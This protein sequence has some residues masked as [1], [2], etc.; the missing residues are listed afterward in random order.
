MST[1][2]LQFQPDNPDIHP[3]ASKNFVHGVAWTKQASFQKFFD[4]GYPLEDIPGSFNDPNQYVLLLYL[5]QSSRPTDYKAQHDLFRTIP[6]AQLA[7]ENCQELQVVIVK[8]KNT[9]YEK[10]MG[11]HQKCVAIMPHWGPAAHVHRFSRPHPETNANATMAPV[12]KKRIR[13][14]SDLPQLEY[15]NHMH[16]KINKE[17]YHFNKVFNPKLVK[18]AWG[19]FAN[20]VQHY[21]SAL[22]ELTPVLQ[23][24]ASGSAAQS[25]FGPGSKDSK[26]V[27]VVMVTNVARIQFLINYVCAAKAIQMDLSNL[28][29]FCLDTA[30][31]Q[32][33]RALELQAYY[34]PN[35][36][37]IPS[38]GKAETGEFGDLRFARIMIAKVYS[39]HLV[40]TL[41][42]DVLFMDT[43]VIPLQPEIVDYFA[44]RWLSAS[45]D[46]KKDI[47]LQYDKNER[48]EQAPFSAN[49]GFYF[50]KHNWKTQYFFETFVRMEEMILRVQS[51]Q[52][53]MIHLL[54]EF[55][56]LVGLKVK[57]MGGYGEDAN[58]FP[59]E[60]KYHAHYTFKGYQ[61][62]QIC[63]VDPS[64]IRD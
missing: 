34:N 41:G 64:C 15:V 47:Y 63:F 29:V 6:N 8:Q 60:Y 14:L 26:G 25:S 39:V 43:D 57:V 40:N 2:S 1:S 61:T 48:F 19:R 46:Q 51:H 27:I 31:Y 28:I 59:S 37:P 38:S 11:R 53:V 55:Q 16:R 52:Q 13:R 24:A 58:L 21:E 36:F 12:A 42:Y 4:L 49:S 18:E 7:T 3:S 17:A 30:S 50:V 62:S 22:K 20:Y 56:S 10:D 23:K 33:A 44:D 32:A 45:S 54:S 5:D 9:R 35:L